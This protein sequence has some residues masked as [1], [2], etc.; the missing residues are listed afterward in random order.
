MS[1]HAGLAFLALGLW[2]V[3][4]GGA[5]LRTFFGLPAEPHARDETR[6]ERNR[7]LYL[8]VVLLIVGAVFLFRGAIWR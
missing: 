7:L 8:G 3:L 5:T 2:I 4:A 1:D 6:S